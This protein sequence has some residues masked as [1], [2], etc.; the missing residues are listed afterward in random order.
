[1]SARD[2][3]QKFAAVVTALLRIVENVDSNRAR[4]YHVYPT[5]LRDN[6]VRALQNA[7]FHVDDYKTC[8]KKTKT[9]LLGPPS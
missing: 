4:D 1:M 6:A 2:T 3:D 5:R 7:G 9:C 8:E